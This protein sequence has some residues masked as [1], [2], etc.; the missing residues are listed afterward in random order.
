MRIPWMLVVVAI[1]VAA[2][3]PVVR[4][5]NTTRPGSAEFQIGDRFEI[6]VTGAANQPVSVRTT[7]N[8][9]TDWGPVIGWTDMSGRWSASGQYEKGDYGDWSEAWTVGGRLASPVFQ[10][11]VNAPCLPG[12]RHTL[13]SMSRLRVETCETSEGLQSFGTPSD[14]EPFRT[15]DGRAIPGRTRANMTAEQL[16]RERMEWR[17][18][19]GGSGVRPRRVG[20]EAAVLISQVTGVNAL[21]ESETRNVLSILRAAFE[22]PERIPRA[23]RNPAATLLLLRRL[24]SGTRQES[25]KRQIA[26]TVAYVQAQ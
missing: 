26:E 14:T 7:M 24:A 11:S 17:I 13:M 6:V 18:T 19:G 4:L 8:G 25:I 2:Q 5:T 22:A 16:Q 21:T 10:F 20:D 15:P 9:R 1:P 23:D 3:S 12:G